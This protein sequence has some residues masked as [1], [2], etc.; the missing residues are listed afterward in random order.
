M[1]ITDILLKSEKPAIYEKG[2]SFM[3]TDPHI[4][5]Q[6]LRIHLDP[7]VDLA[8]RMRT[9]ILITIEWI[10]DLH[11]KLN[12]LSILDLGCGPG[13]YSEIFAQKGHKVTGVDIS[14]NS[15]DHARNSAQT[16]ELEIAYINASYLELELPKER[17][18]LV[19]LIY[20]DFGV[21]LPQERISLLQKIH[22]SLK[23]NGKLIFDV[24][25][26]NNIEQKKTPKNWEVCDS[27]FWKNKPYLALSESFIYK[28]Q[29]VILYQHHIIDSN[30]NIEIY[31]F[32][33]HFFNQ[34]DLELLLKA[35]GFNSILHRDDILPEDGLWNGDNVIF[36]VASKS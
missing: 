4:S 14:K 12:K 5:E 8:S 6:L 26:D 3:W 9:S 18:D 25:K 23:P 36:T 17:Y 10:L 35:A 1:K 31:R 32:W 30:E 22:E 7:D 33:T 11:A 2:T 13:I 19:L 21:L 29:K 24:L 20:A 15:I 16:K 27:G 34:K 28:E